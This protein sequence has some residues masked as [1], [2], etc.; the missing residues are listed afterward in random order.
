MQFTLINGQW[1]SHDQAAV[2]VDDLLIQ[3]GYGVFDFFRLS[4]GCPC[5][6]EQHL[7]RLFHSAGILHL[8]VPAS[9]EMIHGWIEELVAKNGLVNEG[10]RITLTGG[11][12][13]SPLTPGKSSMIMQSQPF[14]HPTPQ[15]FQKG[16][17]LHLFDFQRT[18]AEAKTTDYL[19]A[20]WLRPLLNEQ[21]ADE[22][23]YHHNA[24]ILECPRANIFIVDG[25]GCLCTPAKNVLHGITRHHVLQIAGGLCP[26]E[27]REVGV[28]ELRTASEVFITST[29][30]RVLPVTRINGR[31]IGDG[32]PGPLT[33]QIADC[34]NELF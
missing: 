3:R 22:A 28:E 2:H 13:E 30:K 17:H 10:V 24:S 34:Y 16:I 11:R 32:T 7:D 33:K 26:V 27:A 20:V 1:F 29:T 12:T 14:E 4:K 18:L 6:V 31:L 5:F 19:M 15:Q 23:L 8:E 25:K 21:Q 9:P